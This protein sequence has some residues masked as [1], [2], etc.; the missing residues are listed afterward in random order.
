[1]IEKPAETNPQGVPLI[2]DLIRRSKEFLGGVVT[3]Y[4]WQSIR[5]V[6]HGAM[7]RLI[8]YLTAAALFACSAVF[9]MIAGTEG[10]KQF[11]LAPW[12]AFLLPGIAG[13]LAGWLILK[14]ANNRVQS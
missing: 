8:V 6:L 12:M 4:V 1:M 11:G 7:E 13:V 5:R 3:E 14:C 10:L 2:E 9:L